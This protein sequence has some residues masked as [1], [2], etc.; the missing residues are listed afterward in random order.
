[1]D[2]NLRGYDPNV[3]SLYTIPSVR[4]NGYSQSVRADKLTVWAIEA[5]EQRERLT[6]PSQPP[7]ITLEE[8]T[9]WGRTCPVGTDASSVVPQMALVPNVPELINRFH[10]SLR[11]L[12][13]CNEALS[14]PREGISD[15]QL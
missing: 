15:C 4:G 13:G 12:L 8:I 2:A 7:P 3:D 5:A 11:L 14:K 9:A 6:I 10:P 1:M